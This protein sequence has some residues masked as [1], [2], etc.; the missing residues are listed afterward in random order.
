MP[1]CAPGKGS[2]VWRNFWLRLT[3]ASTQCLRLLWALFYLNLKAE[4]G[5]W[6][7]RPIGSQFHNSGEATENILLLIFRLVFRMIRVQLFAQCKADSAE[8]SATATKT[9]HTILPSV[10]QHCS[11]WCPEG[12]S[13]SKQACSGNPQ[14]L[15]QV[16][17]YRETQLKPW[18]PRIKN[19]PVK[20]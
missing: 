17:T 14:K 7:F 19:I 20:Q 18:W 12:H 8:T 10:L 11:L 13:A 3:I 1:S 16:M 15:F 6:S 4:V 5:H 9:M 2:A